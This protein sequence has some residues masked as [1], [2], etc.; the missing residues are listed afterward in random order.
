MHVFDTKNA[1][2]RAQGPPFRGC[3]SVHDSEWHL[4]SFRNDRVKWVGY[5]GVGPNGPTIKG[6]AASTTPESLMEIY[7]NPSHVSHSEDGL[8]RIFHFAAYNLFFELS[9][10][11]VSFYGINSMST[12]P[13]EYAKKKH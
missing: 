3:R 12:G 4:V 11:G 8:R 1:V 5:S 7:G 2:L 10:S 9:A 13:V 6:V